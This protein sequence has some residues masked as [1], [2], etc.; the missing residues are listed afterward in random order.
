LFRASFDCAR[1]RRSYCWLEAVGTRP[2]LLT[3][4][5][6]L[7]LHRAATL[8][9]QR[10]GQLRLRDNARTPVERALQLQLCLNP[11]TTIQRLLQ[12]LSGSV[13]GRAAITLKSRL[14]GTLCS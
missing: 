12:R 9:V 5:G 2:N 8:A 14:A 13:F 4:D 10:F 6:L 3:L 11:R 1:V 7:R